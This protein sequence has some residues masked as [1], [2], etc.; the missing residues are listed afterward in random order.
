M[1]DK[2]DIK[3]IISSGEGC[4]AEFKVR[5]PKKL[6]DI[7]EEVCAMANAAGGVILIDVDDKN[8]IIGVDIDNSKA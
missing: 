4:N 3:S 5:V 6:K 2:N 8:Q 7:T 1:L